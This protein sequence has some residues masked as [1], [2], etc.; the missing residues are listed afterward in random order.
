MV[1]GFSIYAYYISFFVSLALYNIFQLGEHAE[2][3]FYLSLSVCLSFE[4][5]VRRVINNEVINFVSLVA[6]GFFYSSALMFIF[7]NLNS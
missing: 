3:T 6:M 5:L 7:Y 1:S 4:M 2:M